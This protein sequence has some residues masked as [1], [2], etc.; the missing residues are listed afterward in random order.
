VLVTGIHAHIVP[1]HPFTL[2]LLSG[3]ACALCNNG[4]DSSS[5]FSLHACERWAFYSIK[6]S[7]CQYDKRVAGYWCRASIK[8]QKPR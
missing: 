7:F 3:A 1:G 8:G 6:R 5:C 4:V 2:K